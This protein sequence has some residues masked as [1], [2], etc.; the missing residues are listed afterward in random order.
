MQLHYASSS[1][2]L[3]ELHGKWQERTSYQ[4]RKIQR[5]RQRS[6]LNKLIFLKSNLMILPNG[7][8]DIIS[9]TKVM[10]KGWKSGWK[11]ECKIDH[12]KLKK[13]INNLISTSKS[14]P[15]DKYYLL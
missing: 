13:K 3:K 11:L 10:M 8:Y 12:I 5:N 9:V 1:K 14:I 4:N 7:K 6:R 2:H 15:Q